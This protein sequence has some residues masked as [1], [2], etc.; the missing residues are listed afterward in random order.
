MA[1]EI[2]HFL[3]FDDFSIQNL[4]WAVAKPT[5][6]AIWVFNVNVWRCG[7]SREQAKIIQNEK[8]FI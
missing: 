7:L 4:V 6:E 8:K 3:A 1:D 5:P 2:I